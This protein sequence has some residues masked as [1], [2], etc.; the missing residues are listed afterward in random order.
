MHP[1]D[2]NATEDSVERLKA[3]SIE[4]YQASRKT[5]IKVKLKDIKIVD[6]GWDL[7]KAYKV[8]Q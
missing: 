6:L 5:L 3:K 2:K 1:D 7:R 8:A 4:A